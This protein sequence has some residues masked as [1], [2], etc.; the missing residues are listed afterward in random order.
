MMHEISSM[1]RRLCWQVSGKMF[2]TCVSHGECTSQPRK[3]SPHRHYQA[4]AQDSFDRACNEAEKCNS[5]LSNSR[6][7]SQDFLFFACGAVFSEKSQICSCDFEVVAILF[8]FVTWTPWLQ[9]AR[10]RWKDF[11]FSQTPRETPKV[12]NTRNS[13]FGPGLATGISAC[14]G[15]LVR[16]QVRTPQ[17]QALFGE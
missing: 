15:Q 9:L 6:G 2:A 11:L 14:H 5:N 7:R 17:M 3:V 16:R 8:V 4:G 10:G 12:A 13:N 1:Q